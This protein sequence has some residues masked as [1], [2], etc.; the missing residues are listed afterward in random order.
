MAASAL[1]RSVEE[2]LPQPA[3]D[4]ALTGQ[5][6]KIRDNIKNHVRTYYEFGPVDANIVETHLHDLA[7]ATGMNHVTLHNALL[8]PSTRN[9]S[10]RLFVSWI[11]LS[12]CTGDRQPTLLP[13]EVA[14]FSFPKAG[15]DQRSDG[16]YSKWKVLTAALIQHGREGEVQSSAPRSQN[17]D[18]TIA[19]LDSVLVPF[20]R[21]GVDGGQRRRNLDMILSRSADFAFLLFMQ[22]GSF[23]FDFGGHQGGLVVFPSLI[24]TAGDQGQVLNPPRLLSEQEVVAST[25]L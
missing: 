8:N 9:D 11:I 24:Q 22:P 13:G 25:G 5:I 4:D 19:D 20:V 16:L 2:L 23:R 21:V 12:R 17:F 10:L 6:S 1:P 3:E 14:G 18:Q 15:Q 7:Q